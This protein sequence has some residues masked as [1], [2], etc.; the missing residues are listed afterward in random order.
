ML[1]QRA[2]SG[3]LFNEF[4]EAQAEVMPSFAFKGDMQARSSAESALAVPADHFA[5]DLA[6][7]MAMQNNKFAR[8]N[9]AAILE[10]LPNAT[11]R[12]VDE[13]LLTKVG[14]DKT[15]NLTANVHLANAGRFSDPNFRNRT[16]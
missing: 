10:A 15:E 1:A 5:G 16:A 11:G 7:I 2:A 9:G 6:A 3:R 13:T 4:A 12:Q 14:E 8:G